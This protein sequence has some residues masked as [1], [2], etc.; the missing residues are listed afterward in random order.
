MKLTGYKK[1]IFRPKC[2]PKFTSLH[3][4]AH[5]NDDVSEVLPYLNALLGGAQYFENP[6]ELLLLHHGKLVKVGAREIAIN[7]LRDENEADRILEWLK[8]EINRAW[9]NRFS[10]TPCYTGRERPKVLEILKLLPRTNCRKCGQPT[11]M[12]FAVQVAEGGR[13]PEHCPELGQ[14]AKAKL[15]GYLSR[16]VFD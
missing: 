8:D 4:I 7:A 2:N 11:C 14:A 9:E 5:L 16:F 13:G 1:A 12:V 6:S 10:I 3:C 15:T